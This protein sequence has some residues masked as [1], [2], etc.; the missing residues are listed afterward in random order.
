LMAWAE[1][2]ATSPGSLQTATPLFDGAIAAQPGMVTVLSVKATVPVRDVA[3]D[4]AVTVAVNETAGETFTVAGFN[5]EVT[6]TLVAAVLTLWL[7]VL[8]MLAKFVSL[9]KEAVMVCAPSA[10]PE[11]V[12]IATPLEDG[13]TVAQPGI[14]A[15][16]TLSVKA[17]VPESATLPDGNVSVAV[18]VTGTLNV[19]GLAEVMTAMLVAALFTVCASVLLL[20]TKLRSLA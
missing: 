5:D 16:V 14:A 1:A 19:L 15:D 13:A 17:T 18:K 2:K 7:T 8:L 11:V 4:E 10:R 20:P 3:P 6:T 9:A 12:Q